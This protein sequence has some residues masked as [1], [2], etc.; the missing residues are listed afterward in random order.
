MQMVELQFALKLVPWPYKPFNLQEV[1]KPELIEVLCQALQLDW[2][3]ID[4][5]CN[6][7]FCLHHALSLG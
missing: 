3:D 6:T 7:C 2:T 1:T 4:N 5:R